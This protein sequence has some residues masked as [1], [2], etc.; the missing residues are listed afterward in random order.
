[1]AGEDR[2]WVWADAK[3]E[4]TDTVVVRSDKVARP[5]AVRYAWA[6]NP[7]CNLYNKHGLPAVPFRTDDWKGITAD[8]K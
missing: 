2:R 7:V 8:K 6:N 4:G 3:V 1:M 5:V